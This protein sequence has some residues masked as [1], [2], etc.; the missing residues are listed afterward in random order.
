MEKFYKIKLKNSII[1]WSYKIREEEIKDLLKVKEVIFPKQVHG[2]NIFWLE[3]EEEL[4]CDGIFTK[5]DYTF[6]GI[7]TADCIPLIL[8]NK[9]FI[10][11]IHIGWR[12]LARGILK[13]LK[14]FIEKE[15]SYLK[16]CLFFIGPSIGKCC[17]EV[18]DD[19]GLLFPRFYKNFKLDLKGFLIDFLIEN[20]VK[21]KDI[22][23][24]DICTYCNKDFPSYRREKTGRRILTGIFKKS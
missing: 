9:K 23:L 2:N 11:A 10:G 3:K 19:V 12:G 24:K 8:Y 18:K 22:I 6:I 13:E 5:R 7:K 15:N 1:F 16:E 21:E 4:V 14:V 20:G 17:Y